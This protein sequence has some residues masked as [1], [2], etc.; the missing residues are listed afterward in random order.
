MFN[1]SNSSVE[2]IIINVVI[3]GVL[4]SMELNTGASFSVISESTHERINKVSLTSI[5]K[6]T[7]ELKTYLGE[8]IPI[9]G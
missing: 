7:V 4:I 9:I 1:T 8:S 2:P 3:N 5:V 6:S